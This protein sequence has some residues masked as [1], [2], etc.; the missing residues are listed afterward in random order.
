MCQII[1]ERIKEVTAAAEKKSRFDSKIFS[2]VVGSICKNQMNGIAF[3]FLKHM[4]TIS[5]Y[6]HRM[7]I[8]LFF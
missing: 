7:I 3:Y 4:K 1:E 2:Y 6:C 5:K 8:M